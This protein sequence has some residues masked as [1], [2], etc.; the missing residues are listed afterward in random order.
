MNILK[1]NHRYPKIQGKYINLRE[2][3][4]ADSSFILELRTSPDKSKFI[5]KTDPNLDKQIDYMKNYKTLDNEWYFI[6]EDKNEN[7]VGTI[8]VYPYPIFSDRW[9]DEPSSFHYQKPLGIMGPGRWLMA[10]T[11]HPI[12]GIESDVM[13]KTFFFDVLEHTLMPM[14]IHKDNVSVLNFHKKWGA[15]VV[16]WIDE[17]SHYMLEL[18]KEEYLK[19]RSFYER[20]VY[21]RSSI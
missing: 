21:G 18:R 5:N 2:A 6:V 9:I 10:D 3:E 20:I 14:V 8:S 11:S 12:M 15:I 19:T 7:P 4:V 13:V 16:G 17:I 1:N